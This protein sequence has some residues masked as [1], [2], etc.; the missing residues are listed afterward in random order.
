MVYFITVAD[1]KKGGLTVFNI[2]H[3]R[4]LS[5]F[6]DKARCNKPKNI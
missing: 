5:Y 2:A 4:V 1:I 6:K 3:L